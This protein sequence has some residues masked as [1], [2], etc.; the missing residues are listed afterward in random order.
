M[1]SGFL[2]Q[3]EDIHLAQSKPIEVAVIG[4][5]CASIA[6]AFELTRPEHRGKYHVTM[7]QVGWRLGGK[8]ASGR[9]PA[10]RI[11]EHGLHMWLGFYENA[12]R[13][14]RECYAELDRDPETCPIADWR[15]AFYPDPF[16]G[17]ADLGHE[18]KWLSWTTFFPSA[19][20]QPGDPL[21]DNNPFT[22]S[23]YLARMLG[24]L[25]TLLLD[26]QTRRVAEREP[27]HF[28]GEPRVPPGADS[29]WSDGIG[30]TLNRF[31][32]VG[33]VTSI[34]G[35]IEAITLLELMLKALPNYPENIVLEFVEKVTSSARK[36]FEDLAEKDDDIRYQWEIMDIVL[37][38]MTG[39]FRFGL[40]S[41]PRGFD[42]IDE[43]DCREWLRLN[44]ASRRSLDSAYLRGL[45]D[46]A[47]AYEN[48]DKDR[49]RSAAGQAVRGAVRMLFTYRGQ[50]FW[51]M[52]AGMGDVVFTPFYEVLKKRGVTFKFFHRLA[53]IRLAP[54]DSLKSGEWPYVEALEFDV[55]A[56]I[57]KKI[58][59]YQP[60]VDVD[61]LPCWPS[62]PHFDQLVNGT[63]LKREQW[64]FESH[65]EQRKADELV[66]RVTEDFDFVVLGVGLGAIPH[67]CSELV[68]RDQRWRDMVANVKTVASQAFQVWM[69]ED[70]RELGW[71]APPVT[72]SAFKKPFDTW[73][74]MEQILATERWANR[75]K[76]VA[77]FCGV[78]PDVADPSDE[79]RDDYPFKRSLEVR[80]HAIQFLDQD[81]HHL[82][83][84]AV[85]DSGGFRWGLLVDPD[86]AVDNCSKDKADQS[87]FD[88]QFWTANVNPSDRYVL[89]VP[90]SVKYRISPLDISYDNLT[91]AGDW[92][93][94]G[95]NSGC[96]ESAVMSGRLAAHAISGL[97]ILGDIIGYDHP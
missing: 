84:N 69:R 17:M 56:H 74:D 46:F 40:I 23:A 22:V 48:G 80:S 62:E 90:G 45:Y 10:D 57:R 71:D 25:R 44:G 33:Y 21:S 11:E 43:Y 58:G 92:T 85:S 35:L 39:I 26:V 12:F 14:M 91:I 37:A 53:N 4:G 86:A 13:L 28:D 93:L 82:W 76:S 94:S 77:Y 36:M 54:S 63:R 19:P 24:M 66:L 27:E 88:S 81:V 1:S 8:G 15:D 34:T 65:W 38:T 70:M 20:G 60:L 30:A 52:R 42:A 59:E 7:Y 29:N 83:P 9:G 79:L 67:V 16:V 68:E 55:Q 72:I 73:A 49:P 31:L 50:V 5:G 51:K 75:P 95:L 64:Q 78:L 32:K 3:L 96:V 47:L 89:S 41:D 6:A 61:G 97:P 18:G 2:M 87:G